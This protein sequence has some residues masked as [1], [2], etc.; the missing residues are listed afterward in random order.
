MTSADPQPNPTA[1]LPRVLFLAVSAILAG[2]YLWNALRGPLGTGYDAWGH[3]AYV[4]FLDLYRAVPW[5]D[6][7]WSYFHPPLHYALGWLALQFGDVEFALR[8]IGV[9]GSVAGLSIAALAA[10][11]APTLGR[12]SF[13]C[14][15]S[16]PVLLYAAPMSG[17]ELTAQLFGA[18]ALATLVANQKGRSVSRG[19]D[20][21]TGLWLG[22][23]LWSKFS[24]FI[25]LAAILASVLLCDVLRDRGVMG[26]RSWMGRVALIA[27]IA[28]TIACPYYVRNQLE[29]GTPV[30]LSRSDP[31]VA[32]VEHGQPPGNRGLRD[33]VSVSPRLWVDLRPD[34]PHLIHSVWGSAYVHMWADMR[35]AW[36]GGSRTPDR[37]RLWMV[38]LGV[39]PTLLALAGAAFAVRDGVRGRRRAV[40]LPMLVATAAQLS[41]FVGF[42]VMVP[43][44]S[45]TKASYLLGLA[46]PYGVFA[47]RG[48]EALGSLS[49][50]ARTLGVALVAGIALLGAAANTRG[51]QPSAPQS[52]YVLANAQ[53]AHGEVDAARNLHLE[54]HRAVPHAA[55]WRENLAEIDLAAGDAESARRRLLD[56][57]LAPGKTPYRW[58]VR[59]VA[60][61]L[62]G[63][64][65]EAQQSLRHGLA[66]G[67]RAE[68]LTN[69]GILQARSGDLAAA[70]VT[71]RRAIGLDAALIPAWNA[72]RWT[73]ERAGTRD[74][75]ISHALQ[76][77]ATKAPRGWP[78]GLGAGL[79]QRPGARI[80]MRWMLWPRGDELLLARAPFRDADAVA[81]RELSP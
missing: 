44:L 67:E 63:R 25:A 65:G 3:V 9:W 30:R 64:S 66:A 13:V 16:L 34:A 50:S 60:Q 7:G 48:V 59:A 18:L 37:L 35:E 54:A 8:A 19:L 26:W 71:L 79:G 43:L 14:V 20:V 75:S 51:I 45:A 23:M 47:A 61:A 39:F 6:Q 24:G 29:F 28:L 46:L 52:H 72:L 10:R 11:C 57:T 78:Y 2:V 53:F 1:A 36:T 74:E 33:F 77:S 58:N 81:M 15:A 38:R 49:T 55:V 42:N 21:L 32:G 17:N 40:Y 5:A 70:E 27:G 68:L 69:L 62:S 76:R 22:A 12:V 73:V 4:L 41:S 80:G 56:T 31:V